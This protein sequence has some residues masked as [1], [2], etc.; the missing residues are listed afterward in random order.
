MVGVAQS[1]STLSGYDPEVWALVNASPDAMIVI[2]DGRH[3]FANAR[4]LALYGARDLAELADRPALGYMA[5]GHRRA[6]QTRLAAMAVDREQLSYVQ[7]AVLRRDGSVCDIESAGSPILFRGRPAAL[8]VM[9]DVTDRNAAERARVAAEARFQAAFTH[10]P[11]GIGLLDADGVVTELNEAL[12]AALRTT[13]DEIVGR[14]IWRWVHPE[15]QHASQDR[16]GRLRHGVTATIQSELRLNRGDGSTGW[17]RAQ[18]SVLPPERHGPAPQFVLQLEDTSAR[19]AAE[20]Q[21]RRQAVSDSLTGLA[22][23]ATFTRALHD[24]LA[25]ARAEHLGVLFI[26]LD[27][28]KVVNDSLGHGA[29]DELLLAVARRLRAAVRAGDLVARL[30]GDEFAVLLD[31]CNSAEAG[32]AA[33]RLL[34][35]LAPPVDLTVASTPMYA[36]ASIGIACAP[37]G[38][39]AAAV[40]RD[41]DVAMYRAKAAGGGC[42]VEFDEAMRTAATSR[43]R[44]QNGLY[45]ALPNGEFELH[46]QPV[47]R[48]RSRRVGGWEAL[49]RWRPGHGDLV[50][51]D[52]FVPIAEDTGLII[53]IGDWV[54]RRAVEQVQQW[55]AADPDR[56]PMRMAVNVSARQLL[57]ADFGTTMHRLARAVH[58]D[59]LAIEITGTAAVSVTPQ[60]VATLQSIRAAGVHVCID[61]FGTGH[62]SLARLRALPVDV[63][64]IDRQFI[65][66]VN[67]NAG[68]RTIVRAIVAMA[69]ALDITTIAE[70]VETEE[71]A[72]V[73]E[74]LGCTLAQG[75]LYGRPQPAHRATGI[76]PGSPGTAD[77][78]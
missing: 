75:Y 10:A 23:R 21:L 73:V 1:V 64:K 2:Q 39:D 12:A 16:F 49:L 6:G 57:T 54:L 32:H 47:V 50:P 36:T 60:A 63:L 35:A 38:V 68:D 70:G 3:V 53:P 28:F 42:C 18:T 7:E 20:D 31:P 61:D 37:R 27:R 13:R 59:R 76:P 44:L 34:T 45:Q 78:R 66:T 40:L 4:A 52:Q 43:L 25:T 15:E 46:Y 51:P 69:D 65:R 74:E 22:N 30:G 9:R 48:A 41:A 55:R 8:V 67:D 14:S 71:Q 24:A 77:H 72:R 56:S 33:G 19:H 5:P 26:D 62:S 11:F 17:G 29:G 58:P